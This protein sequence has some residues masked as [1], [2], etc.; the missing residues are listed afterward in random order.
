MKTNSTAYFTVFF[1]CLFVQQITYAQRVPKINIEDFKGTEEDAVKKID[2]LEILISKA[3]TEGLDVTKEKMTIS[4]AK[5]FLLY[6]NWDENN[7][8]LNEPLLKTIQSFHQ[9][10]AANL[11]EHLATFER[12]EVIMMV[13][14]AISTVKA[15]INGD[16]IRRSIP[17]IDWSKVSVVK[18]ELIE[19]G[20]P[21][22]LNDYTWKPGSASTY[23]LN[24]YLGNLSTFYTAPSHV[25]NESGAIASYILNDLNSKP[26][27]TIGGVFIGQTSVPNWLKT[28]YPTINKGGSEFFKY[29]I[30]SPGMREIMQKLLAGVGPIIKGKNYNKLGYMLT[31]EPHWNISG[32]WDVVEF[33]DYAKDSLRTWLKDKHKTIEN[34]NIRWGKNFTSFDD[35]IIP[36]LPINE[37]E[38]GT[39]VWYDLIRFNQDRVASGYQFMADE[40]K[41]ND[42]E[43]KS[44]IKIIPGFF[45]GGS[46]HSGIDFEQLTNITST[47]GND[48]GTHNSR[49]WGS[50]EKWEARYSYHWRELSL[51]YDFLRSVA[52]NKINYNSESHFLSAGSFRDLFLS[53]SYARSAYWLATLQGMN[54]SQSWYWPRE[55]DGSI[56]AKEGKGYAG[57]NVQQPRIVNEIASTYMDLNANAD[58]ISALQHKKQPIRIFYSESAAINRGSFMDDI[59]DIYESLYFEG[60]SIGFATENIIKTQ[61]NSN[62]DVILIYNTESSTIA[63]M[64]ALQLYLDNGGTVILDS[65]SLKKDEYGKVHMLVLNNDKGGVLTTVSTLSDFAVKAKNIADTKHRFPSITLSETNSLG[66]KG[67]VWRAYTSIDGKE[68]I[69]IVNIGKTQASVTLGLRGATNAITCVNLLTGEKLNADFTMKPEAVLLLEVREKTA[70]DNKF[71]I[72]INGETCVGENNGKINIIPDVEQ[73][74]IATFNG[75]DSNFT[76]DL[77]LEGV[78]PGTYNLCISV[79]GET[80]MQCYSLKVEAAT[81]ITGKSSLISNMIAVELEK[82]TP[83]FSIDVNGK[84][85]YETYSDAFSIGVNQGDKV[86]IKSSI[87]CEGVLLETVD[88]SGYIKAF[89]NPTTGSV[90]F[91]LPIPGKEITINLYNTQ[92][93]LLSSKV[94]PV[95]GGTVELSVGDKPVGIYFAK[96]LGEVPINIKIIK[97]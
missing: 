89:P 82:G 20:K 66:L 73:N 10:T 87:A 12:S 31:N 55:S 46:R 45:T 63:E 4:T 81:T 60:L 70:E 50:Q 93:K 14:E 19:N 95:M 37:S 2:T 18:N 97:N 26:S 69:S 6:A 96:V 80:F 86:Q 78:S 25:A 48:A 47:I 72:T 30:S 9:T 59:F 43:G 3:E 27:G 76:D 22:F 39:P 34:L 23:N 11:A 1:M 16:V 90:Q 33:S 84:M 56:R 44:H 54:V 21:V 74:Y 7:K 62:W 85:V 57:S 79:A 91:A 24:E 53:P 52:P 51:S 40:I 94:Y 92:S 36:S 35:V 83:P 38:R 61:A 8:E 65:K 28:K 5:I 32:T 42:P 58:H 77:T 15:I 68:I 88:F 75:T 17:I 67:C 13:E 64:E 71:T 29:D 41:K 49:M